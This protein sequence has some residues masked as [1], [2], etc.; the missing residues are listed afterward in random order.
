VR[1]VRADAE[2]LREPLGVEQPE[3]GLSV[4][5]VDCEQQERA[6]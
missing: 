1:R 2:L 4:A 5:D 6:A 3:D